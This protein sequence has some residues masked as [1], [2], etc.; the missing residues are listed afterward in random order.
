MLQAL[1]Q[2]DRKVTYYD[3]CHM[4]RMLGLREEP[5]QLLES[6]NGSLHEMRESD[7]CCGFGGLFSIRMPEVSNAMTGEKLLQAMESGADVMV[8]ADPGCLLQMRGLAQEGAPPI[9]HL[10][11]ILEEATR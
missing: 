2:P 6:V 8:T 3:S 10:A 4:C 7:R 1:Y 5:R 9:K 11:T